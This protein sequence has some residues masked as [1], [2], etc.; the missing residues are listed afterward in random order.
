MSGDHNSRSCEVVFGMSMS[1]IWHTEH[2]LLGHGVLEEDDRGHNDDDTFE[3]VANGVGDGC[4]A[5]QDHVGH[6]HAKLSV[7]GHVW[8]TGS[9]ILIHAAFLGL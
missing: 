6:L 8:T 1:E 5:S 2:V 7:Y 4:D 9:Q 3:A